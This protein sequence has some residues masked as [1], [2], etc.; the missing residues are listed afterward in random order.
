[1]LTFFGHHFPREGYGYATIQIARELQRLNAGVRVVDMRIDDHFS[2]PGAFDWRADGTA[3]PLLTP[4][5]LPSITAERV[6]AFTMFEATKLPAGW[7]DLINAHAQACLV[8]CQWCAEVFRHNGVRVPIRVVPLGINSADYFPAPYHPHPGPL[9]RGEG[10]RPYTFLWTGTPD[11][12]KG[13]DVAYRAFIQAF[14][15]DRRVRL[16]LHFREPLPANPRFGDPNVVV[17]HGLISLPEMRQMFWESDCF[18]YPS[19]GEGWGS[20]PREAA[21]A[22]LPVIATDYGGLHEEIEHWARPLRI[23]GLSPAE[24]GWFS[25]ELGQ[26]IGEW[27]EPDVHHLAELMTACVA[28]PLDAELFGQRA[29]AWLANNATYERT[30]RGMA[31]AVEQQ[32]AV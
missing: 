10:A 13:W 24:Y 23:S 15:H 5:W 19:R 20:P 3:V 28:E 22:G 12:R 25:R 9:P 29:A 26:D 30:A 14:G 32:E 11:R 31:A 4:L 16:H 2:T 18:V 6:I 17:T 21:A 8:P 1:M 27:A 7:A